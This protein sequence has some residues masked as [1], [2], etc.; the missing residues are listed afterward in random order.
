MLHFTRFTF[1]LTLLRWSSVV[2]QTSLYIPGFDPQPISANVVGVGSDGRTT[3]ALQK[4]QADATDTKSYADFH[5]T[6]TLVEGP[7]DA[8][9]TYADASALFTIGVTCTF[10]HSTLAVCAI[11]QGGSTATQ[12]EVITHV[13]VQGQSATPTATNPITTGAP[14]AISSGLPSVNGSASATSP[15]ASPG[16]NGGVS[17]AITSQTPA[18]VNNSPSLSSPNPLQTQTQSNAAENPFGR[19]PVSRAITTP[20]CLSVAI[21]VMLSIVV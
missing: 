4:G 11:A 7:K 14:L 13:P 1:L 20:L 5:G 19:W 17:S 21:L 15:S 10:T 3:W 2:A 6:A 9:L 16:P 18:P 12:T 8:F